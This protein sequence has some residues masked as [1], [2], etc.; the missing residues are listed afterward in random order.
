MVWILLVAFVTLLIFHINAEIKL[1]TW[2]KSYN[3][4]SQALKYTEAKLAE[5]TK[6][7]N[8][9]VSSYERERSELMDTCRELRDNWRV[10]QDSIPE[11]LLIR[12]RQLEAEFAL[13]A[14]SI[15]E[16]AV[17]KSKVVNKG[18]DG[19]T[20]SPLLQNRWM[21]RDFRHMGDP[22]D[23]LV[24]A[25]ADN[26]RSGLEDEI[27]S[28]VLLEVKTGSSDL[29]KVQRKIRD[30]VIAGKVE[31]CLYNPDTKIIRSWSINNPKGKDNA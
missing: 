16:D 2:I 8:E 1:S 24:L 26:V 7:H 19:E 12:T 18:F 6:Y 13:K 15:R 23:F 3:N 25:G 14:K 4:T 31:F 22:I 21:S 10:L 28:I 20:F 27:M 30:A 11:Q 5:C 9:Q 17:Q 29:N